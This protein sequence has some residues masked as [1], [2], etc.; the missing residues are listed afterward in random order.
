MI[1]IEN[2][3][4]KTVPP[5][6][7][8]IVFHP[9]DAI[10]DDWGQRILRQIASDGAIRTVRMY[11][12]FEDMVTLDEAGKM[13]FDFAL[14]DKRIDFLLELGFVPMISYSFLPPWLCVHTEFTS[15]VAKNKTRYKGKIITTSYA[16]DPAL[17]GE[18]CRIYTEHLRDRY[19]AERV[20]EWVLQCYNEPD[21]EVFFMA[22]AGPRSDPA[23]MA[24]RLKEYFKLYQAFAAAVK[25]VDPAF[26]IGNSIASH[27]SFMEGFLQKIVETGTPLDYMGIH[28]YGTSVKG[29][30]S[31]EDPFDA[32]ACIKKAQAFW[33][34]MRRVLG[35]EI[36]VI[37]DEWGASSAGFFNVE[38]CPKLILREKSAFAAYFGKLITRYA[39]SSEYPERLMICLSGQHEMTTDFS[40]FRNFFTLNFFKKPIYNAHILA[41]HLGETMLKKSGVPDRMTVYP[42]RT[43]EGRIA[44]LVAYAS[45][46]FDETLP[47][48]EV[49]LDLS[50]FPGAYRAALWR[51]DEQHTNPYAL[52]LREGFTEP[53][54]AEEVKRLA[55]EGELKK[56][57]LAWQGGAP[58]RLTLASDSLTLVELVQVTK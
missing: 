19:N 24:A 23:A 53:Y 40:G 3:A 12:M 28:T 56:E 51:I 15:S 44:I 27:R 13:R 42:T 29:L 9:T 17:W 35:R 18:I 57:E 1:R 2:A 20:R 50:D 33:E 22:E 25:G 41:S 39:E 10:E 7:N 26:R 6:W 4:A 52:A 55:E 45:E 54:S 14:N 46:H 48:A 16:K 30:N 58:L 5:F 31:G 34:I 32:F 43:K 38:E 11:T 21:L 47:E 8:G 49:E 37:C 36:P